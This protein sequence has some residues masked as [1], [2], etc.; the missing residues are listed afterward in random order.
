MRRFACAAALLC[1][2]ILAQAEEAGSP[3]LSLEVVGLAYGLIVESPRISAA[4]S[5]PIAGRLSLQASPSIA[6]GGEEGSR[7]LELAL[8]VSVRLELGR[9]CARPYA[10]AGLEL[11]WGRLP[12]GAAVVAAGPILEVGARLGL[13]GSR[14]YLEP[15]AGGAL[16]VSSLPD[17]PALAPSLLGGMRLGVYCGPWPSFSRSP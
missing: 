3:S 4:A 2:A 5:F 14:F 16:M 8:P 12:G 1:A 9:G 7:L 17:G 6:W 10:A 11:G 15:Y 13:F